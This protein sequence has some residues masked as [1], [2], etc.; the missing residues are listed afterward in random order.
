MKA[1]HRVPHQ[2]VATFPDGSQ[3]LVT[4]WLS[5]EFDVARR[6]HSG[7]VWGPPARGVVEHDPF[8]EVA[9]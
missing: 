9:S 3:V 7:A 6:E 1:D 8:G 4:E 2:V 5:G